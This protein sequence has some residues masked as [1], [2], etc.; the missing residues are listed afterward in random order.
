M[1]FVPNLGAQMN[2]DHEITFVNR[3][4]EFAELDHLSQKSGL[5]VISEVKF[6]TLSPTE[7][8]QI[9]DQLKMKW[10]QSMLSKKYTRPQFEILDIMRLSK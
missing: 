10:G 3:T 4:R 9:L 7:R 1:L 6:K 2:Y 8:S 5:I